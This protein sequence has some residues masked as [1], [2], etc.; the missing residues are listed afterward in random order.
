MRRKKYTIF[1]HIFIIFLFITSWRIYSQQNRYPL[2]VEVSPTAW[3]HFNLYDKDPLVFLIM[4]ELRI[5]FCDALDAYVQ[6]KNNIRNINENQD[7][8]CIIDAMDNLVNDITS[9]DIVVVNGIPIPSFKKEIKITFFFDANFGAQ[10]GTNRI[11]TN[12]FRGDQDLHAGTDNDYKI[13]IYNAFR[14]FTLQ[15]ITAVVQKP[16]NIQCEYHH[17]LFHFTVP[18]GARLRPPWQRDGTPRFSIESSML[19]EL[20]HIALKGSGGRYQDEATV[21]D[22]MLK[23]FPSSNGGFNAFEYQFDFN[24][25]YLQEE[26]NNIF[27][28]KANSVDR[29]FNPFDYL[30]YEV[31][32][33]TLSNNYTYT[34]DTYADDARCEAIMRY[35]IPNKCCR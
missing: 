1:I 16:N 15:R 35:I 13:Y 29:R 26:N 18:P 5:A 31:G 21:E 10:F 4:K 25:Y 2:F 30:R 27:G 34:D 8:Q 24:L 22:I 32:G 14:D 6:N 33:H 19:H 23:I 9:F 12:D 7:T 20:I 28:F 17:V 3:R 11:S